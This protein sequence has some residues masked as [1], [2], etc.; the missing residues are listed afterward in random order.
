MSNLT[1]YSPGSPVRLRDWR[2][3]RQVAALE[4]STFLGKARIQQSA[5]LEATKVQ[6]VGFVT[7]QGL[8][9]V[10]MV[11]QMEGLLGQACPLAVTRLQGIADTGALAI[12]QVVA[13]S[14]REVA[15]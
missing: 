11:S 9:T 4:G 3:A 8:Q 10:T 1:P 12:A 14:V 7:M 2:L 5:E 13:D 6:A 15:R